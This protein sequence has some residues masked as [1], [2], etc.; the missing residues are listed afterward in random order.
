MKYTLLFILILFLLLLYKKHNTE[1][2]SIQYIPRDL[3]GNAKCIKNDTE[4]D[5]SHFMCLM[6]RKY[7][8]IHM[9][10]NAIK[11]QNFVP[12]VKEIPNVSFKL[13]S[14]L[15]AGLTPPPLFS[16]T[17]FSLIGTNTDSITKKVTLNDHTK[18]MKIYNY[19]DSKLLLFNDLPK[20]LKPVSSS[21]DDISFL[22]LPQSLIKY[23]SYLD[24]MKILLS[25]IDV[26]KINTLPNIAKQFKL[27]L[28]GKLIPIV[29]P[30][31]D[32]FRLQREIVIIY[33]DYT[34]INVLNIRFNQIITWYDSNNVEHNDVST[35]NINTKCHYLMIYSCRDKD[36]SFRDKDDSLI[37]ST[38][39]KINQY[40]S[41]LISRN[42][43]SEYDLN[44]LLDK[45][46]NI[47]KHNILYINWYMNDPVDFNIELVKRI[48]G[49]L[50]F[51]NYFD[52]KPADPKVPF[53]YYKNICP[54]P[55]NNTPYM[56]RCYSKCPKGYT[57][58]GLSCV[59]DKDRDK[60]FNP[61]SNFCT[62]V[63]N[64]SYTD[65]S[66]FDQI[67]QQGCW[68]KS[69]YCNKC[70]EFSIGKCNC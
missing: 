33:D 3:V 56:G 45:V 4:I 30:S 9:N 64:A 22:Y 5:N 65:L 38:I 26:N 35:I 14:T 12:Y 42:L 63:C 21:L 11:Y 28:E 50:I 18:L 31:T 32:K 24:D 60:L 46:S 58:L 55:V 70:S 6:S 62:Q 47:S 66:N 13:L 51:M 36:D 68:C 29:K 43:I 69:A 10:V 37:K 59:L 52:L 53:S 27:Y 25:Y 57:S 1:N 23:L 19:I 39:E 20:D 34:K 8:P 44:D 49:D 16:D 7:F 2:F 54:D 48:N 41:Y 40:G 67:L 15:T 17:D 61:D